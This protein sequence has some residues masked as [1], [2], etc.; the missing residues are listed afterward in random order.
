MGETVTDRSLVYVRAEDLERWNCR[1]IGAIPVLDLKDHAVGHVDGLIIE[2]PAKQPRFLVIFRD[3]SKSRDRLLIP[4][5]DAWFDETERAIRIDASL[6]HGA[7]QQ[8]DLDRLERMSAAET[9][10]LE[11]RILKQCCPEVPIQS[12]NTP[13]YAASKSFK[14]PPWVR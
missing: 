11:R 7:L 14:C 10:E 8:I 1:P 3:D 13:H 6:R 4:V 2:N 12:D 5:N 9:A